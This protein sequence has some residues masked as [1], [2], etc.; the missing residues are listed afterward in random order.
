MEIDKIDITNCSVG[1]TAFQKKSEFGPGA[2]TIKGLSMEKVGIP[3]LV[4][5]QSTLIVNEQIIE[6]SQTNVK[7]SLLSGT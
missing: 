5:E 4:E 6:A 3:Y 1:V 2:I 7:D